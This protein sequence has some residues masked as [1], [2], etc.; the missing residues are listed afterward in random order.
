[1]I[2][3]RC[4]C[5]SAG[6]PVQH[7]ASDRSISDP[8]FASAQSGVFISGTRTLLQALGGNP[9][10]NDRGGTRST[11]NCWPCPARSLEDHWIQHEWQQQ[12]TVESGLW[13]SPAVSEFK[14]L[15]CATAAT[16]AAANVITKIALLPEIRA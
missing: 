16:A 5:Q 13:S 9:G 3:F 12:K 8:E 11:K 2:C 4:T 7:F 1:M 6:S 14:F 10:A 15:S